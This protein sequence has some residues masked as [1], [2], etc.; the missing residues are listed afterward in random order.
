MKPSGDVGMKR[1]LIVEDDRD[2]R[3]IY[4]YMFKEQSRRYKINL[5]R[6]ARS[7][8][9]L[10]GRERFDLVIS[11]VIM[12]TMSGESFLARLREREKHSN[13]PVLIVTVLGADMLRRLKGMKRV[14]Y[15][16]KPITKDAMLKKVAGIVRA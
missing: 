4:R 2:M 7:A 6:D 11:D 12:E 16:Q 1:L 14:Y 3:E 10:L 13:V 5:V 8:L 15:L 9:P